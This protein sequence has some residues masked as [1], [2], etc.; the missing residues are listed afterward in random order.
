MRFD[1]A[2]RRLLIWLAAAVV[3]WAVVIGV[4]LYLPQAL[5][6]FALAGVL[7]WRKGQRPV[8]LTVPAG[9]ATPGRNAPQVSTPAAPRVRDDVRE[10]VATSV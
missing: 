1:G 3:G 8:D 4:C 7:L 5:V 2:A 9:L 10:L 6:G